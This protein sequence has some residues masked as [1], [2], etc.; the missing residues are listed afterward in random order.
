MHP[1]RNR[2]SRGSSLGPAACLGASPEGSLGGER[3]VIQPECLERVKRRWGRKPAEFLL[4]CLRGACDLCIRISTCMGVGSSSTVRCES[5]SLPEH[6]CNY[7]CMEMFDVLTFSCDGGF[8]EPGR[9][10]R[11]GS[12]AVVCT[13]VFCGGIKSPEVRVAALS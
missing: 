1:V 9:C 8:L 5:S 10:L 13:A 3:G 7:R 2:L 6:G 4:P 11:P 12:A